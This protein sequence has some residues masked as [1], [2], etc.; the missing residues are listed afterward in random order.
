MV[1][2]TNVRGTGGIGGRDKLSFL[3]ASEV[4]ELYRKLRETCVKN[5]NY[6]SSRSELMVPRYDEKA[7][8]TSKKR[9][10]YFNVSVEPIS[11]QFCIRM[12]FSGQFHE[13]S[14]TCPGNFRRIFDQFPGN[15]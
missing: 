5:S 15:V 12:E 13:F 7:K 9:N 11:V 2:Q 10:E 4:P 3:V 1:F 8:L 6:F 14:G